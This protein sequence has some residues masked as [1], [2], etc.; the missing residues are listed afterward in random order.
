MSFERSLCTLDITSL[1]YIKF[2]NILSFHSY[3]C[4]SGVI[5]CVQGGMATVTSVFQKGE[6]SHFDKAQPVRLFFFLL[7]S[8]AKDLLILL[9]FDLT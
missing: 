3:Q 8:M 6:V 9:P 4:L 5:G 1:M 2:A 7:F